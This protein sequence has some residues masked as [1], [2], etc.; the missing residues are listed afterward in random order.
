[1]QLV[2]FVYREHLFSHTRRF[3][4]SKTSC[5]EGNPGYNDGAGAETLTNLTRGSKEAICQV[6]CQI[7]GRKRV[8]LYYLQGVIIIPAADPRHWRSVHSITLHIWGQIHKSYYL[9]SS[10]RRLLPARRYF[11]SDP[12]VMSDGQTDGQMSLRTHPHLP[13]TPARPTA[14]ADAPAQE[15][16]G[17]PW[18]AHTGPSNV[19]QVK[20]LIDAMMWASKQDH[21]MHT[22]QALPLFQVSPRS[23][24]SQQQLTRTLGWGSLFSLY[25]TLN[26]FGISHYF[27]SWKVTLNYLEDPQALKPFPAAPQTP[28]LPPQPRCFQILEPGNF[29]PLISL[30]QG[31]QAKPPQ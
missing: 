26:S 11:V 1:M 17:H 30:Q 15:D 18:A 13:F 8:G 14:L 27:L 23:K 5:K 12:Q 16:H 29:I 9:L 19:M 20:Q 2:T 10:P 25:T 24:T 6:S 21:K 7:Q 31:K 3:Q 22:Q 4:L 28:L